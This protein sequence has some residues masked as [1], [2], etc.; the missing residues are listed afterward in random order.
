MA[1]N[2][3]TLAK[4]MKSAMDGVPEPDRA[5]Q[6]KT[7]E[8]L[9]GAIIEHFQKFG[10]VTITAAGL[11]APPGTAGGPVTGGATGKIS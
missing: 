5:D 2:K 11:L 6:M 8:A 3:K 4:A 9:A 10:L 7:Y 1:L